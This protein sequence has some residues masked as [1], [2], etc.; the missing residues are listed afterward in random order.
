MRPLL[1]PC[2]AALAASLLLVAC[3]GDQASPTAPTAAPAMALSA[4]RTVPIQASHTYRFDF[5]CSAAAAAN[6]LVHITNDGAIGSIYVT[7][8]SGTELGMAYGTAFSNF[9]V[10]ITLDSP[11][12]VKVC[13]QEGLTR[14]VTF[15]CR[16]QKYSASLTVTDEGELPIGGI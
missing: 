10:D 1:V 7:C 15:K 9:G 16:S 13:T 4:S 11:A 8:N 2:L 3:S 14:T 5:A 6:S 12:G